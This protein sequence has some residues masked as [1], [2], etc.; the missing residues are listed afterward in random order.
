MDKNLECGGLP[1]VG[2]LAAAF[3]QG[4]PFDSAQGK[5]APVHGEPVQGEPALQVGPFLVGCF[6]EMSTEPDG[7]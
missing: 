5:Q 3:P 6:K 1:A 2:R 4:E 7:P